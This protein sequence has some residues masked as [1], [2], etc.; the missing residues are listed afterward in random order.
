MG[1]M[2]ARW[3]RKHVYDENGVAI[4][5]F[6]EPEVVVRGSTGKVS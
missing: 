1:Q 3:V 5:T 2:A 4:Q 6:F